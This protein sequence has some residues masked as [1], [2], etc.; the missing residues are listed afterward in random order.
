MF[1]DRRDAGIRLASRLLQYKDNKDVLVLALP[2]GGVATSYEVAQ[3]LGV[4]LDVLI[5]RKIGVPWQP[6]LAAGAVS[7]TGAL[8]LNKLI[9]SGYRISKEFL[10]K[11][12]SRQK[13]E[14][15]RRVELYRKGNSIIDPDGKIVILIDDGVATGATMKAAIETLRAAKTKKIVVALPV[16]PPDTADELKGMSDDF[17]CIETHQDFLAVGN[18]YLDFTQVSDEEV[19]EFL[20]KSKDPMTD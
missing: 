4:P 9:V 14:I 7:E 13:D 12:I 11:E 18:Y 16:A 19:V 2:R 20:Q 17:I 15:S 1:K 6:E 10:E 8:V 5:V 3:S